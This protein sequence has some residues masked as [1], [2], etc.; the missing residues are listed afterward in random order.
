MKDFV[1]ELTCR[2]MIHQ[3]MPGTDELLKK[4]QV[5]AYLGI[6]NHP[7]E[8]IEEIDGVI[9]F[10]YRGGAIGTA[11]E[12]VIAN[13]P[14]VAIYNILGQ[15]QATTNIELLPSGTYIVVKTSGSYKIVR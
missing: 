6:E 11:I 10:K 4:E 7:I 9:K 12:N 15:K 2:G 5:T 3:M 8:E 14:I 1:Q 13:E